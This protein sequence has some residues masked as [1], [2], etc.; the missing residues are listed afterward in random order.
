M[1]FFLSSIMLSVSQV[2]LPMK[3][4]KSFDCTTQTLS[5]WPS[6]YASISRAPQ[7]ALLILARSKPQL[8]SSMKDSLLDTFART[9]FSQ[10][11]CEAKL[12][13]DRASVGG[14]GTSVAASDER[15]PPS[16]R[17]MQRQVLGSISG[18]RCRN[19]TLQY[20]TSGTVYISMKRW[21]AS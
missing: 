9:D 12:G 4:L 7:C 18:N 1:T 14:G 17:K 5:R 6:R 16:R 19:R 13:Q 8:P 21:K 2:L 15:R 11:L 20:S 3:S 10:I